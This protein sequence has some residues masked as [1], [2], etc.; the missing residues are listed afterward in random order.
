MHDANVLLTGAYHVCEEQAG[1]Y[2]S[3]Y[4]DGEQDGVD[5]AAFP[6]TRR[7][8]PTYKKPQ[9]EH[10]ENVEFNS[11]LSAIWVKVEHENGLVKSRFKGLRKIR[12]LLIR[13]TD[14]VKVVNFIVTGNVLHNIL[15]DLADGEWNYNNISGE[16]WEQSDCEAYDDCLTDLRGRWEVGLEKREIVKRKVLDAHGLLE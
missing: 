5:E 1:G 15:V 3:A 9:T 2:D 6:A 12:M 16:F 7:L 13:T 4:F 8:V 10:F 14:I 11:L